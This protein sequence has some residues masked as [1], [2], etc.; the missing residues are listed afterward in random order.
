M[1]KAQG[2]VGRRPRSAR[3]QGVKSVN[4]ALQGGGA[5]G[6]FAWGVLDRLL[7]EDAIAFDGIS[8]TSAGAVNAIV[9]AYGL[10]K[11]GR[12]G[13]REA[14][15]DFWQ[16]IS[17]AARLSPLQ[18]S[19]FDRV[20]GNYSLETS[21]VFLLFH[22]LTQVVSPYE[23]NP[24]NYNPLLDVL[25]QVVDFELLRRNSQIKLFLSATNVRSGKIRVFENH[26]MSAEVVLASTCL[27]FIFQAV[28]IGEDHYW[29][30]GYMGN[31]ALFPLI[32]NCDCS[33]ILVVHI[34]PISRPNVPT[35]AAEILNRINEISFNSSLMREIRAVEFLNRLVDE[36]RAPTPH[37]R[38]VRL[39][40]VAADEVMQQLGAAS[41]LNADWDFL[42]DLYVIGREKAGAWL[43]GDF[44]KVG[45]ESSIDIRSKYL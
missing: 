39:H 40:A 19:F 37:I 44:T 21:P 24:F 18:P 9:C 12:D 14:L 20:I 28:R 6:A 41:K 15:R 3:R 31:P 45:I 38:Q 2:G 23:L 34:N 22:M 35:T 30:G 33:D 25:E 8:A 42:N 43:Q 7:E 4:L 13:A 17:C 5:H 26:E 32:Y 27:P 10:S 11:G 1:N 29:D 36:G 16:K